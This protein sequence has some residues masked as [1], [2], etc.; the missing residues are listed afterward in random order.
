MK[1]PLGWAGTGV[2]ERGGGGA[3]PSRDSDPVLSREAS[4][5]H[6]LITLSQMLNGLRQPGSG[7]RIVFFLG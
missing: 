6:P 4:A 2:G 3:G 7:S 1:Q 5:D